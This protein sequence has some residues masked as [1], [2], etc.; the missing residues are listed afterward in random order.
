MSSESPIEPR[1]IEPPR[2]GFPERSDVDAIVL[3]REVN[4][5]FGDYD[6]SVITVVK[7]LREAGAVA[8]YEHDQKARRWIGENAVETIALDL[9]LNVMGSAAW[10]ALCAVLRRHRSEQVRVRWTRSR[11]PETGI[12]T[13]WFE[14]EGPGEDVAT[15]LEAMQTDETPTANDGNE[16]AP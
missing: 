15:A 16:R 6:S 4:D 9:I 8:A 3:A 11:D 12:E 5:G 7:E 13:Q 1:E 2:R 14:A 10:A